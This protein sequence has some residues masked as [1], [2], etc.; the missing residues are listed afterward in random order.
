MCITRNISAELGVP[1]CQRAAN[2][3]NLGSLSQFS[4]YVPNLDHNILL[5]WTKCCYTLGFHAIC[6]AQI[7]KSEI[8]C[9]WAL[10][11]FYYINI[12]L[13]KSVFLIMFIENVIQVA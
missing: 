6:C 13:I 1:D 4:F 9:L 5:T 11:T 7:Y 3:F 8:C 2:S 10:P 12:M